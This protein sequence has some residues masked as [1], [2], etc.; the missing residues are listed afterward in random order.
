MQPGDGAT[1]PSVVDI[2][3]SVPTSTP[4]SLMES[5]SFTIVFSGLALSSFDAER[6]ALFISDVAYAAGVDRTSVYITGTA[7]GSTLVSA[8]VHS[9]STS[10]TSSSAFAAT[11]SSNPSGVLLSFADS[12]TFGTITSHNVSAVFLDTLMPSL[13]PTSISLRTSSPTGAPTNAHAPSMGYSPTAGS[14]TSSTSSPTFV[15]SEPSDDKS[16]IDPMDTDATTSPSTRSPTFFVS[17]FESKH[18][19]QIINCSHRHGNCDPKVT[20]TDSAEGP[21]CGPCPEG[22]VL[23]PEDGLCSDINACLSEPCFPGVFCDD[24]PAPD[25]GYICG[26]CPN[27]TIGN[28]VDCIP[29]KC[30][31]NY[32]GC[33]V[34]VTCT[35]DESVALGRVCGPCPPGYTDENQDGTS[36]VNTDGC[37]S[38]PCYPGVLCTDMVAPLIGR[39]CGSCP[40]GYAGDGE[41]CV[42]I[43]ECL[44]DNGGCDSLT[45]CIDIPG[46]SQ[47]GPCPAGYMG[48]GSTVCIPMTS[49]DTNNG[50]CD[51]RTVCVE[52]VPVQCGPCPD[53]FEGDGNTG[54]LDPNECLPH[55]CFPGTTCV[56]ATS[57]S[58]GFQCGLCPEGYWGDGITCTLCE[59][60]VTIVEA[61]LVDGE[62]QR[63]QLNQVVGNMFGLDHPECVNTA[64]VQFQWHLASSLGVSH[65]LT[66][67]WNN[68]DTLRLVL[69]K[70]SLEALE[71]Y[72][73]Q[74]T[75]SLVGQPLV[76]SKDQLRFSVVLPSLETLIGGGNVQVSDA[77]TVVLDGSASSDPASEPGIMRFLWTCERDDELPCRTA[78]GETLPTRLTG[79]TLEMRFEAAEGRS[80][81][82]TVGLV[83]SL[84]VRTATAY[85][86]VLL[87]PRREEITSVPPI[88]LID[89]INPKVAPNKKLSLTAVVVSEDAP[90]NVSLVW[91]AELLNA[92]VN[93][94]ATFDL[95]TSAATS[96]KSD[97]L[98]VKANTLPIGSVTRFQ[99]TAWDSFAPLGGVSG[100]IDITANTPP[101]YGT[102]D[103]APRNGYQLHT[104]FT[105][106]ISGWHDEDLPLW[107]QLKCE[108]VGSGE[109]ATLTEFTPSYTSIDL[110]IPMVGLP[111]HGNLVKVFVVVRDALG[112]EASNFTTVEVS[113]VVLENEDEQTEFLNS[114][115]STSQSDL[116]NGN[117]EASMLIVS[118][119]ASMLNSPTSAL[120]LHRQRRLAEM[121]ASDYSPTDSEVETQSGAW[122]TDMAKIVDDSMKSICRRECDATTVDWVA[123]VIDDVVALPSE[124]GAETRNTT[125]QILDNLLGVSRS[126]SIESSDSM[127]NSLSNVVTAGEENS[128]A[129]EVMDVAVN[130]RAKLDS[131]A[132]LMLNDLS[133]GE[134][135]METASQTMSLKVL[136]A[137]KLGPS[138]NPLFTR[139][140]TSPGADPSVQVAVNLPPSIANGFDPTAQV[141]LK[142]VT[143]ATNPHPTANRSESVPGQSAS[144]VVTISLDS[145]SAREPM[146][147]SNLTEPLT[148]SIPMTSETEGTRCRLSS[149][150]YCLVLR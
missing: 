66:N 59:L 71:T 51:P 24:L 77:T 50:G 8:T 121:D 45:T 10:N 7:S 135:A 83:I 93:S 56:D 134:D 80:L 19:D 26:K 40:S 31:D 63:S 90:S 2:I 20:C 136:N 18:E 62:M 78:D 75:A 79:A 73:V 94:N 65:T 32:G 69:P 1:S 128:S 107:Y 111:A 112:A 146:E 30:L 140:V 67:E 126:I 27:G 25:G 15:S 14:K 132:N 127:I 60:T 101:R 102:L 38:S 58:T 55:P 131:I 92:G 114:L 34:L 35:N 104:M 106:S 42:N 97:V 54:C 100:F 53:G 109:V 130:A 72:T 119:A 82:Y 57:P 108:A 138:T 29:N 85:T 87:F 115:L 86:T 110:M 39:T 88:P 21:V 52:G 150:C 11:I 98:V 22:F 89:P 120:S 144:S 12:S 122:R 61:S 4:A 64:G 149:V 118:G 103:V 5:I 33:D 6:R 148:F 125:F 37:S 147:I 41:S 137:G 9:L 129:S 43:D 49:C 133:G 68:A 95:Q 145:V 74:L 99:L 17:E 142:L 48:S 44:T 36:C 23:D 16:E 84:G 28:G 76:S 3:T 13:I 117:V 123:H 46:S 91:T 70:N 47:C 105:V 139:A 116:Q 143:M 124:V 113:E 81:L 141:S 96:L